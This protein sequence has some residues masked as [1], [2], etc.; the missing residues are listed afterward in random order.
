MLQSVGERHR[1]ILETMTRNHGW[2]LWNVGGSAR[3]RLGCMLWSVSG[4]VLWSIRSLMG[5]LGGNLR[6]Q[7]VTFPARFLIDIACGK[8]SGMVANGDHMSMRLCNCHKYKL[9]KQVQIS[10]SC[11]SKISTTAG[12]SRTGHKYYLFSAVM[13]LNGC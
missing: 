5:F 8:W 13:T 2:V 10:Q 6:E 4:Q 1:Q 9:V 12:I 7:V 11:C 3:A